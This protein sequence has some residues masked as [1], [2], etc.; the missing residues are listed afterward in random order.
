M[1][2]YCP[3]GLGLYYIFHFSHGFITHT[4]LV[5]VIGRFLPF[6]FFLLVGQP[7][8]SPNGFFYSVHIFY[9]YDFLFITFLASQPNTR[10][11]PKTFTIQP[12]A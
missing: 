2:L 4:F 7:H 6:P 1:D 5:L 8:G 11:F 9:N 12:Y 3:L 10:L